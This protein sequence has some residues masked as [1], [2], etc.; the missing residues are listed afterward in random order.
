MNFRAGDVRTAIC[1]TIA[2]VP[3][4][5]LD[6][7][8]VGAGGFWGTYAEDVA[9][10]PFGRPCDPLITIHHVTDPQ[11]LHR[12]HLA[13]S[14]LPPKAQFTFA[15]AYPAVARVADHKMLVA[16]EGKIRKGAW[17]DGWEIMRTKVGAQFQGSLRN[18][19]VLLGAGKKV[20]GS[21]VQ[22]LTLTSP[23][24][25]TDGDRHALLCA[26][27]CHQLCSA[28]EECV[29]WTLDVSLKPTDM[30]AKRTCIL[31]A[32]LPIPQGPNGVPPA[33][34][35]R[36]EWTE[37]EKAANTK[38]AKETWKDMATPWTGMIYKG[39]RRWLDLGETCATPR[40]R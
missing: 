10:W 25:G 5:E 37:E 35:E 40:A 8:D 18:V 24:N 6:R 39:L 12:L 20:D 22:D 29:S 7:H 26:L 19:T 27:A 21:V 32:N 13:A 11:M 15:A 36:W 30:S 9:K 2:G 38:L 17:R 1:M 33:W 4:I 16:E 28:N 14:K 31:A 34:P 23:F 3:L